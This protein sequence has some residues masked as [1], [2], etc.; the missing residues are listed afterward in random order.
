MAIYPPPYAVGLLYVSPIAT[1]RDRSEA[2]IALA[3]R[4]AQE[5]YAL[6]ETYECGGNALNEDVALEALEELAFRLDAVAV[7]YAGPVNMVRVQ[8]IA[9]RVRMVVIGTA[10]PESRSSS[11]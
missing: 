9:K 11:N 1:L 10:R 5:G 7:L 4:A 8:D 2:R 3:L 6:I